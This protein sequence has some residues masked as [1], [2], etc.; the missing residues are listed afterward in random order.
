MNQWYLARG[1]VK[2]GPYSLA[3]LQALASKGDLGT[4]D[5]LLQEGT[6]QWVAAGAVSG[7]FPVSAEPAFA[8]PVAVP[9]PPA[10]PAAVL[11]QPAVPSSALP[12]VSASAAAVGHDASF[13]DGNPAFEAPP[14][15]TPPPD[16]VQEFHQ[17]LRKLTPRIYFTPAI[18]AVNVAIFVIMIASGVSP[19]DPTADSLVHWGANFAPATTAGEWWRL[20]TCTFL[21]IGIVHLLLNMWVLF[22]IGNLVE[23]LVGNAG[24]LVLYLLSGLAASLATI[25]WNPLVV[26]AGA[27]GAIFGVWGAFLGFLLLRHDSIPMEGLSRLRNS[28][29]AFLGYNLIFGLMQPNIDMA[30]HIGGL[31]FGFMAGLG[32][33]QPLTHEALAGRRFRN[34]LVGVIGCVVLAV[35][36]SLVPK[37]SNW[38]EALQNFEKV[39]AK[40]IKAYNSAVEQARQGRLPDADA[41]RIV[42]QD[43]LPEWRNA[44]GRLAELKDV[45][46][47]KRELVS[48][49]LEYAKLRQESWELFAAAAKEG[50]PQKMGLA[51][52]RAQ[53]AEQAV[54]RIQA[55]TNTKK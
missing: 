43:V 28:G 52:E 15:L 3:E 50:N 21:H 51:N 23:R 29:L 6:Q 10:A 13:L 30:A 18:I 46:A 33:S 17:N 45:P 16:P 8:N 36:I 40:A 41:A 37:P 26:S 7:L 34:L 27:S 35:S 47:A 2:K 49:L 11:E 42:E 31:A 19:L 48:T 4:L 12:S 44:R 38:F 25:Y 9:A 22:D 20:C 5:M 39:E 53:A 24:F 32:L 1:K 14:P 54:R 55:L